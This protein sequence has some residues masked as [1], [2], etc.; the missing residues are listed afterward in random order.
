MRKIKNRGLVVFC[1]IAACAVFSCVYA[2]FADAGTSDANA[3]F[4]KHR[5][6]SKDYVAQIFIEGVITAST[7]T[8]NQEWLLK[9]ISELQSDSKNKGILLFLNTPGGGV[10]EAD[11]VYLALLQ[12][13]TQTG[14]PVYA[15]LGPMAASGGYYIACAADKIIANRNTLTGSIGVIFGASMDATALLEKLGVK[16][17]TFHTGANKNMLNYN[18]PVTD[19]QRAIMQSISDEAYRQFTGI[20]AESRSLDI[21]AVYALADG[22]IYTASQAHSCGLV[23]EIGTHS[24]ALY[25]MQTAVQ[26]ADIVIE[27]FRYEKEASLR[28]LL[29]DSA[30]KSIRQQLLSAQEPQLQAYYRSR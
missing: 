7:R 30:F 23:D 28:A 25:L 21:D 27:D 3:R 24:E 6:P 12:Y 14:R 1:V 19:E 11:E 20:V 2:S 16:S 13:K 18:E 10:Y 8:Y 4:T 15:Y 26:N 22:R 5:L 29:L 9:T 17:E